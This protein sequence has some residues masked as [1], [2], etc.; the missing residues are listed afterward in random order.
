MAA[1]P[2]ALIS[3]SLLFFLLFHP[4]SLSI[5]FRHFN[6]RFISHEHTHNFIYIFNSPKT[7]CYLHLSLVGRVDTFFRAFWCAYGNL[8]KTILFSSQ[9]VKFRVCRVSC[10]FFIGSRPHFFFVS[11]SLI[12]IYQPYH[13]KKTIHL[14]KFIN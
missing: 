7:F 9:S 5:C 6:W 3:R 10:L 12:H 8:F 11:Y 14:K 1:P 4:P 2:T 13:F